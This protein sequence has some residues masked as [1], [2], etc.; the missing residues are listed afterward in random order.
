MF[1]VV[2]INIYPT[3][4]NETAKPN[5]WHRLAAG[6]SGDNRP[7]FPLQYVMCTKCEEDSL[8][9]FHSIRGIL[10]LSRLLSKH[11]L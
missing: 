3:D 1:E 4:L 8:Y 11:S 7:E 6:E 9:I 10:F 5:Y 2:V